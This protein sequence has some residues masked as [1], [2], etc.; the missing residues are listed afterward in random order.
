MTRYT[1]KGFVAAVILISTSVQATAQ[2]SA[3]ADANREQMIDLL[4]PTQSGRLTE[5]IFEPAGAP[6]LGSGHYHAWI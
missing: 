5:T 2:D 4:A 6:E 1:M 3:T